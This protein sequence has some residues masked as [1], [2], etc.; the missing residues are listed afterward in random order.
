MRYCEIITAT[1][2]RSRK[3][4]FCRFGSERNGTAH[5]S[6][7]AEPTYVAIVGNLERR[8]IINMKTKKQLSIYLAAALC[9]GLLALI[10]CWLG[11][12]EPFGSRDI[13]SADAKIQYIDL[14][15]YL[16]DVLTGKQSVEY[17]FSKTL[18]G[19]MIA[20]F[21][22]YLA[23]PFNLIILFFKKENLYSFYT[24]VWILKMMC[25]S[26]TCAIF[27]LNRFRKMKVE[28]V[29]LLSVSY[30][31][32]QYNIG[33]AKNIMWLDG[34][35]ML[36]L[37]LLGVYRLVESRKKLLLIFAVG[38]AIIC[39][40][41]TGAVDCAFSFFYLLYEIGIGEKVADKQGVKL[42]TL[43]GTY[44]YCMAV[45]VCLSS[46]LFLP[47]A[48]SMAG[49]RGGLELEELN[50]ALQAEPW[51]I[52]QGFVVGARSTKGM[53]SLYCGSIVL[54]GATASF[55]LEES[56]KKKLCKVLLLIFGFMMLYWEP[57]YFMFSLFKSVG[58]YDYRYSYLSIMILIIL[59]AEYYKEQKV[60]IRVLAIAG[61]LSLA[62]IGSGS[63][64]DINNTE[65]VVITLVFTLVTCILL[66]R[67][68]QVS[69]KKIKPLLSGL[70]L[71]C[72][73]GELSTNMYLLIQNYTDYGAVQFTAYA[74]AQQEQIQQLKEKDSGFYRINQIETFNMSGKRATV[75][76][77]E[78]LAYNYYSIDGY[79]SDPN[80]VERSLLDKLG[81][82]KK[83]N[84]MCVT[85]TS[86]LTA[87]SL[88]G[89]KYIL[90]EEDVPG[91]QKVKE[92][93][94]A[95]GKTVYENPYVL[96]LMFAVPQESTNVK[97]K[98]KNPFDYQNELYSQ[99]IGRNVQLYSKMESK[100]TVEGNSITYYI[101][102]PKETTLG[103]W[104]IKTKKH[105]MANAYV[106]EEFCAEVGRGKQPNILWL[107]GSKDKIVALK[108]INNI[109][110]LKKSVFYAL[111]IQEW[112]TV[113]TYIQ[114]KSG[115]NI[116]AEEGKITC[117]AIS[118]GG[119][120]LLVS[121]PY[122]NGWRAYV[123]G[124]KAEIDLVDDGFM[125]VSLMAGNNNVEFIYQ[126]PGKYAGMALS[127]FGILN[128]L[129][130]WRKSKRDKKKKEENKIGENIINNTML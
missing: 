112:E 48:F 42:H 32:M 130:L 86:I 81:Y 9:T 93:Q 46:F 119:E 104:Y 29:L 17:S 71:L 80:E 88:L 19:G 126:M 57:L 99:L 122:E 26:T 74:K 1:Q 76:F 90:S 11:K 43:F 101:N 7:T 52:F 109:S 117:S 95:N 51:N 33:Q 25:A 37:I 65:Q 49:G 24:I 77:N 73:G 110:S 67:N 124:E 12:Y 121:V 123:N 23:S 68:Q 36:P 15:A 116:Q 6:K 31:M 63:M 59:A 40:W 8:W 72:L 87:D 64:R 97:I 127:V 83:G 35:Y 44:V 10:V 18:G 13:V 55:F 38:V 106:G 115:K 50:A 54:I 45:G 16:K 47:T 128:V 108:D 61:I 75:N 111:D 5:E 120:A 70:L 53:A 27:L 20:V 92:V 103:Y 4:G 66:F 30:A 79:T 82:R 2:D 94:E 21:A 89:V 91:T 3:K 84:N 129:L 85:N 60:N 28:F 125:A 69:G 102:Y 100:S 56:G 58:S 22:Y 96:P 113:C 105:F 39:N 114:T 62:V 107:D 14:F 78:A 34:V 118:D 98:D 41:Y